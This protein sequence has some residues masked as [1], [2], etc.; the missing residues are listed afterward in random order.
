[1]GNPRSS[2]NSNSPSPAPAAKL[3]LNNPDVPT[4]A[5]EALPAR[6]KVEFNLSQPGQTRI[7]I[8]GN[9]VGTLQTL[10]NEGSVVSTRG[11][12]I[13][14]ADGSAVNLASK[15]RE[16]VVEASY[17]PGWAARITPGDQ[18]A[19]RFDAAK[20]TVDV[21]TTSK[22]KQS[23][24]MRFPDAGMAELD[25]DSAARFDYFKDQS[26]YV[27]GFG[28]VKTQSADGQVVFLS[29]Q[30][31]MSAPSLQAGTIE[32]SI[33][34]APRPPMVGG[35]LP[36]IPPAISTPLTIWRNGRKPGNSAASAAAVAASM[37]SGVVMQVS[38]DQSWAK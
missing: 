18:A 30:L 32:R 2:M 28:R 9:E 38:G 26:Y 33:S 3:N 5:A 12:D 36:P 23:V 24:I 10:L 11:V 22:N 4:A 16:I 17:L 20:T 8:D 31:P 6:A 13:S 37:E 15:T 21:L 14:Y 19:F 27:S 34:E 35:P 25:V 1:M 7:S 29:H